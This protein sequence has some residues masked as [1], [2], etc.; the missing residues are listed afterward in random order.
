MENQQMKT[1]ASNFLCPLL[2]LHRQQG[3]A[4]TLSYVMTFPLLVWLVALV[5]EATL[6]LSTKIGT[7]YAANASARAV[8]VWDA[9]DPP[10]ARKQATTAAVRAMTPFASSRAVH[11]SSTTL[12]A[13]EFAEA[14]AP[15]ARLPMSDAANYLAAKYSYAE[16]ATRV[17]F[18]APTAW[19]D[20]VE[21]TVSYE[22]PLH[23]P[24]LGLLIGRSAP[25]GGQFRTC[26]IESLAILNNEGPA[27]PNQKL[28]ID[29]APHKN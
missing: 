12:A 7:V 13:R 2:K 10:Y 17:E 5:V 22:A 15:Y 8:I 11:G 14:F 3:A 16:R 26:P 21:V 27:S 1:V 20:D 6:L 28:Q 23:V 9:I 29:Y 24:G 4:Y 19:N 18:Q 25:F